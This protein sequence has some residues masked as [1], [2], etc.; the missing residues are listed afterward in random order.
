M[1]IIDKIFRDKKG[2]SGIYILLVLGIL[3]IVLG[4]GGG[5]KNKE[6]KKSSEQIKIVENSLKDELE[7]TLCEIKGAGSVTVMLTYEND[8]EKNFGY[9]TTGKD[10]KTVIL[11]KQGSQ[12]ALVSSQKHA[13]IR[14]VIII[15]DGGGNIKV[16][17]SLIKAAQTVLSLPAHKIEVFERNE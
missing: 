11:N 1:K 10:K 9:D 6:E 4:S 8:G 3:L 5:E 12:E 13:S 2:N 7:K 16:K 15:A 14:G 17:E